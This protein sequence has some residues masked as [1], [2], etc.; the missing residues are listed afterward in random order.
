MSSGS[1]T[2]D[3]EASTRDD[4]DAKHEHHDRD[5]NVNASQ[6]ADGLPVPPHVAIVGGGPAGIAACKALTC[7]GISCVL[8]EGNQQLGGL[9]VTAYPGAATQVRAACINGFLPVFVVDVQSGKN[10]QSFVDRNC[11]QHSF[12]GLCLP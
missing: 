4:V 1:S 12:W 9:W 7:R 8:F 2:R 10:W 11:A 5:R 3:T 6:V